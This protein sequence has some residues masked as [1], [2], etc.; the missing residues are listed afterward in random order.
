MNEKEYFLHKK[1]N[2]KIILRVFYAICALLLLVDLVY[3]RHVTHPWEALFGFHAFYGL[4]ACV[5]LVLV[6]REMRKILM[7]EEDYY[8]EDFQ[9]VEPTAVTDKEVDHGV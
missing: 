8:E 3:H 5:L 7:R 9:H 4:G 1:R 6:A 2:V